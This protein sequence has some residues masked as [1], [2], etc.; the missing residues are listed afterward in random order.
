MSE[1]PGFQTKSQLRSLLDAAGL[2]PRKRLGQC[3]LIDRNLMHKLIDSA[4]IGPRDCILEVGGGTGSLTCM[5]AARAGR[6]VSVEIDEGVAAIARD[7][8]A[9]FDNVQHLLG[10]ALASKSQLSAELVQAVRAASAESHSPLKLVANLPYDIATALVIDLLLSNLGVERLCFTVQTEVADR[11]LATPGTKDFGPVSIIT[12][13]L[14]EAHR[15]AKAPAQAFW[16][17][18]KVSSTLVRLDRRASK[19]V[20]IDD[21]AAF[22]AFVR[23]FFNYRRKTLANAAKQLEID[24]TA[25]NR[26]GLDPVAR[27]EVIGIHEWIRLFHSARAR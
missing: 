21:P 5:L 23:P 26:A 9:A 17:A 11:F 20:P 3:F 13:V 1:K 24:A 2:S 19:D 12:Q 25:I 8:L 14:C 6:V 10:D 7:L 4:E 15:V 16:P 18:P 22:A 27:P